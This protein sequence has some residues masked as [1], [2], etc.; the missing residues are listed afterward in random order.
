MKWLK[1]SALVAIALPFVLFLLFILYEGF[2][3]YVNHTATDRQTK[4]VQRAL[5]ENL[6][7]MRILYVQFFTGNF[8]GT[9]DHVDCVSEITFSSQMAE[10]EIGSILSE[11]C[12][13]NG[14]E[15]DFGT[16]TYGA[17]VFTVIGNAPFGDNI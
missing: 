13:E 14:M 5:I 7:D 6:P 9:G 2:G 4:Q 3:M 12:N 10:Q 8:S 15:Y 16:T 17:Y 11:H 1:R